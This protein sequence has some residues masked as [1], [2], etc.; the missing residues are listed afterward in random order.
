MKQRLALF[1]ATLGLVSGV[2]FAAMPAVG[3]INVFDKCDT[4]EAKD[5]PVCAEADTDSI[6]NPIQNVVGLLLFAI[7]TISVIMIIVG[8]IRYVLSYGEAAKIKSAKDTILYA[9]VGLVVSLLAYAIVGF[10]LNQ[11][12]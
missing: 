3:A 12:G 2:A 8:G 9:V 1:V 7:G 11:F 5:S 4:K 10:V 6:N